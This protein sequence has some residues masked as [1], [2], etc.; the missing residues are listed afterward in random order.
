M[1]NPEPPSS[2]G[3]LS[4]LATYDSDEEIGNTPKNEPSEDV[5]KPPVVSNS[6]VNA[7]KSAQQS[8]IIENLSP[9][10]ERQ[11][12][13]MDEEFSENASAVGKPEGGSQGGGGEYNMLPSE[14]E[15]DDEKRFSDEEDNNAKAGESG[16]VSYTAQGDEIEDEEGV[17]GLDGGKE[18]GEKSDDGSDDGGEKNVEEGEEAADLD[19]IS[20]IE[21]LVPDW[22]KGVDFS[23]PN[24]LAT[25]LH[26]VKPKKEDI[27]LPPPSKKKCPKDLQ[28]KFERHHAAVK[29]GKDL[30]KLI[31]SKTEYRNPSI[32]DKLVQHL[33]INEKG[34][35]F[36]KSVFNPRGF[37][38]TA[39]YDELARI[40]NELHAKKQQQKNS[41]PQ[42]G[43]LLGPHA[44]SGHVQT[45]SAIA[46]KAVDLKRP[47][48][49]G[50]GGTADDS[51]RKSKWDMAPP[52]SSGTSLSNSSTI[53][54]ASGPLKKPKVDV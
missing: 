54:P 18:E 33:H 36:P 32:Y 41:S 17:V 5:E 42:T 45:S 35:N 11:G 38:R 12:M 22:M 13:A 24:S 21:E 49:G 53:I 27:V 19:P 39:Y 8:P 43:G 25:L 47:V 51:G 2:L 29:M 6:D 52:H 10:K 15:S 16:L 37:P 14:F 50:S 44:V 30:V 26:K 46:E 40:Q 28:E 48:G 1:S 7:P 9:G 4:S 20:M 3:L 31:E 34:T 23:E